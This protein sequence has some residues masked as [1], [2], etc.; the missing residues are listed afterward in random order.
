MALQSYNTPAIQTAPVRQKVSNFLTPSI[1]DLVFIQTVEGYRGQHPEYGT[2][3]PD[4]E[5][6]PNHVLCYVK[7]EDP[8]GAVFSYYYAAKRES[9]DLYN[10]EYVQ[11]D[12]NGKTARDGQK[13]DAVKRTYFILRSEYDETSISMGEQ[14]ADPEDQF[15]GAYVL[16][17]RNQSRVQDKELDSI[18]VLDEQTF[19]KKVTLLEARYDE[20]TGRGDQDKNFVYYRGEYPPEYPKNSPNAATIED[21]FDDP[22]HPYWGLQPEGTGVIRVGDQLSDNWFAVKEGSV[23]APAAE[24][25]ASN[26]AKKRQV[27]RTTPLASDILFIETGTVLETE[28]VYGTPHYDATLWPNHK[29]CYVTPTQGDQSGLMYDFYYV[30]DRE[31]QKD[32]NLEKIA[33]SVSNDFGYTTYRRTY[34]HL[35]GTGDTVI[36]DNPVSGTVELKRET[37]L[38]GLKE[39]DGLYE[40]TVIIYGNPPQ[41]KVIKV[42][43]KSVPD[44]YLTL[45][46]KEITRQ[47]SLSPLSVSSSLPIGNKEEL[48]QDGR[49]YIKDTTVQTEITTLN[50]AR[51]YVEREPVTITESIVSDTAPVD[52]GLTIFDSQV[53]PIGNGLAVKTTATAV[54]AGVNLYSGSEWDEVLGTQINYV[55]YYSNTPVTAAFTNVQCINKDRYLI[56]T[57]TPPTREDLAHLDYEYAGITNMDFP[58]IFE[59]ATVLWDNSKGEGEHSSD[60]YGYSKGK[61]RSLTGDEDGSS[62]AYALVHPVVS[63]NMSHKPGRNLPTRTYVYYDVLGKTFSGFMPQIQTATFSIIAVTQKV[64]VMVKVGGHASTRQEDDEGGDTVERD[65]SVTTSS[66]EDKDLT[67]STDVISVGPCIVRGSV[68][69]GSQSETVTAS[70]KVEWYGQN[71]PSVSVTKTAT[72]TATGS[73]TANI[74]GGSGFIP[75]GTFIIDVAVR[76]YKWGLALYSVTQ[77]TI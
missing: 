32:Y 60:W 30:A 14:M 38:T 21:I 35:R 1:A 39:L 25:S 10:W 18:Y 71:F 23:I 11:A 63:V 69:T 46:K 62:S 5:K 56:R 17:Q 2:K 9:Q 41:N 42:I 20:R 34:V 26:P 70:A 4:S 73:V 13:F 33:D 67:I 15:D 75:R 64:N 19:I 76:P 54:G 37:T 72:G 55:E 66:G 57:Y 29:L 3:H 28:P 24:N 8:T 40:K 45:S 31:N 36:F 58:P 52:T 12:I 47:T 16:A 77:V 48:T 65:E 59:G 22:T 44:K 53:T 50:G 6:W 68:Q 74:S 61:S 51:S 7:Q 49:V 43:D 27:V